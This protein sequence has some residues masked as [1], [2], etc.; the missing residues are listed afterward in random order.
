M[1]EDEVRQEDEQRQRVEEEDLNMEQEELDQEQPGMLVVQEVVGNAQGFEEEGDV[2]V[3]L[4]EFQ[5]QEQ[6]TETELTKKST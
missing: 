4:K 1:D 6:V 5:P 3:G 2:S